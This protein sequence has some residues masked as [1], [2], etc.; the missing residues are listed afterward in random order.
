MIGAVLLTAVFAGVAPA[1]VPAAFLVLVAIVA[2]GR[3]RSTAEL[4][5]LV[6]R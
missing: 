2:W 1:A 6:R 4:V 5:A 3:R